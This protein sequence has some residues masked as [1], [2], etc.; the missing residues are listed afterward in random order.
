MLIEGIELRWMIFKVVWLWKMNIFF[1]VKF[2]ILSYIE[3]YFKV[4]GY[5]DKNFKYNVWILSD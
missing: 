5:E 3:I 1:Y 4:F 2:Y